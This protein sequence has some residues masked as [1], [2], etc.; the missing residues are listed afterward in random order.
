MVIIK[1]SFLD[2][3]YAGRKMPLPYMMVI[4]SALCIFSQ[5]LKRKRLCMS[6][7]FGVERPRISRNNKN[8]F[9]IIFEILLHYTGL[10][11]HILCFFG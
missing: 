1:E 8:E 2:I 7:K 10:G 11:F 5:A 6:I 9:Y 3:I 4:L